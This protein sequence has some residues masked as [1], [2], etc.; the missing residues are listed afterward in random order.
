MM[1][2]YLKVFFILQAIISFSGSNSGVV[3]HALLADIENNHLE[4]FEPSNKKD[5]IS[6]DSHATL[7]TGP[8]TYQLKKVFHS[9]SYQSP[10]LTPAYLAVINSRAPPRFT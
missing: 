6:D 1:I 5:P 7:N 3:D 8:K 4:L 10:N 9:K 2:R